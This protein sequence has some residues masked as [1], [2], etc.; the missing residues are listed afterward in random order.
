[1]LDTSLLNGWRTINIL[2][3]LWGLYIQSYI[4]RVYLASR[5]QLKGIVSLGFDDKVENKVGLISKVI[6]FEPIKIF[7]VL[8]AYRKLT[9]KVLNFIQNAIMIEI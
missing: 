1:M 6:H 9:Q 4:G 8:N 2:C 3:S 7:F 5:K